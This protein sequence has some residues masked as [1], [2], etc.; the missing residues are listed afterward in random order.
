MTKSTTDYILVQKKAKPQNYTRWS[1]L[2]WCG[3]IDANRALLIIV[4]LNF[5]SGMILSKAQNPKHY[6]FQKVNLTV[7]K[8]NV[9]VDIL[10]LLVDER[11]KY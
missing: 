7:S 10:F 4:I 1:L 5:Y 11:L 6:I 8:I 2:A 3:G 9:N